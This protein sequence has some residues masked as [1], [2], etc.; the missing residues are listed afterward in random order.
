VAVTDL[1]ANWNFVNPSFG[2]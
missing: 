1:K 2:W